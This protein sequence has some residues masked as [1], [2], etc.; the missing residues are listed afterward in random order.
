MTTRD[1]ADMRALGTANAAQ[2]T[3]L[4][5]DDDADAGMSGDDAIETLAYLIRRARVLAA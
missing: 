1:L 3:E 4:A 2:L 5:D